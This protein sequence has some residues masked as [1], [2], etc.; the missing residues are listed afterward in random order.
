VI[1]MT[2]AEFQ[3]LDP[4]DIKDGP[5]V[6]VLGGDED[7]H[8][9]TQRYHFYVIPHPEGEMPHRI[10]GIAGQIDASRGK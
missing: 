8:W 1:E 5:C 6:K 4:D 10:A 2:W 7:A 3:T 9:D